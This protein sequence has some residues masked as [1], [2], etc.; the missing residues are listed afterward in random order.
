MQKYSDLRVWRVSQEFA[1]AIYDVTDLFPKTETFGMVSQLRRAAT[2]VFANIAEGARREHPADYARSLNIAQASLAEI[3]SF[4]IFARDR[5][6]VAVDTARQL[7]D[8]ANSLGAQL[9]RL[10]VE[11]VR[12]GK[13]P[14]R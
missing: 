1:H 13:A 6:F 12:A 2:S 5:R 8:R 14:N 10:R 3:E 7:L 11:V 4:L 9:Q